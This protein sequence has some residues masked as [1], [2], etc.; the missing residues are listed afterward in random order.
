MLMVV[1]LPA[2]ALRWPLWLSDRPPPSSPKAASV[3]SNNLIFRGWVLPSNSQPRARRLRRAGRRAGPER[4]GGASLPAPTRV[5]SRPQLFPG[6]AHSRSA[7]PKGPSVPGPAG[8]PAVWSLCQ[9]FHDKTRRKNIRIKSPRNCRH[10]L[11]PRR[12]KRE[13]AGF[14]PARE[15]R[16]SPAVC[17]D[18]K[19][20]G[21]V[22]LASC[23]KPRERVLFT[24]VS[25]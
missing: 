11:L 1:P 7:N 14:G 24:R 2:S 20:L 23:P 19:A 18:F 8:R 15:A 3:S 12:V 16:R 10:P 25:E 13:V 9:R 17:L 21:K 4:R 22:D 5:W 6:S